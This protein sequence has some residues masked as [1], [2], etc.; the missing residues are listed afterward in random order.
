[1]EM[2]RGRCPKNT[3]SMAEQREEGR[4]QKIADTG[5]ISFSRFQFQFYGVPG[6]TPFTPLMS[7]FGRKADID[8]RCRNVRF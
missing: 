3:R 7:A 4:Q 6:D 8:W 1:M 5:G 2:I